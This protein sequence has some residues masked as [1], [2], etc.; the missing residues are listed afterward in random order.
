MDSPSSI[1]KA[2][3]TKLGVGAGLGHQKVRK[4]KGWEFPGNFLEFRLESVAH[5]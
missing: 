3:V 5:L 1:D 2:K 4:N